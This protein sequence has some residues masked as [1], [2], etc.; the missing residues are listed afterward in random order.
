MMKS[1]CAVL[2]ILIVT[3]AAPATQT[4]VGD[5]K[6]LEVLL[7]AEQVDDA[8]VGV[9]GSRSERYDAF[10]ELWN[11]GDSVRESIDRL[12]EKGTPAGRIYGL[13]L[14]RNLDFDAAARTARNLKGVGG[15]VNV[16][17][18]CLMMKHQFAELSLIHI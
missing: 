4:N 3:V 11:E 6:A 7:H 14:L 9:A 10:A 15:E 8:A 13:I 2:A 1:I 18:G 17:Q 16:L 5:E 12:I